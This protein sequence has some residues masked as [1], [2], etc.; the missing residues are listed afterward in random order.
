MIQNEMRC[1]CVN[2]AA[3]FD[4]VDT[5][6][7][8]STT[9]ASKC[10]SAWGISACTVSTVTQT[11]HFPREYSSPFNSRTVREG[12]NCAHSWAPLSAHAGV[13]PVRG[14]T[15]RAATRARAATQLHSVPRRYGSQRSVSA[16]ASTLRDPASAQHVAL[17]IRARCA[18]V[19]AR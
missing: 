7:R 14:T 4:T 11:R 3:Q 5:V 16:C 12:R 8:L 19:P 6:A 2:C 1:N 18:R 15:A 13:Q 9:R 10:A 17:L